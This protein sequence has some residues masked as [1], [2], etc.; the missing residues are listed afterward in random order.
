M[1]Q[2]LARLAAGYSV[3]GALIWLFWPDSF[4]FANN[5]E[6]WFALLTTLVVWHAAEFKHS[7]ELTSSNPT[8]LDVKLG[9]RIVELHQGDFRYLLN[10]VSLWSFVPAD[11][12]G[13]ARHLIDDC[14]VGKVFFSHPRLQKKFAVFIDS[15]G[16][17]STKVAMETTEEKIAGKWMIGYKPTEH[18]TQEQYDSR[19]SKSKEADTMAVTSWRLLEE[20]IADIRTAIPA[21]YTN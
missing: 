4:A 10:E 16:E 5:P 18:I 20:L 13:E 21:A 1:R 15:L 7:E 8:Q 17:L 14:R 2:T 9:R 12:Y 3:I 11:V 19:M 6:A